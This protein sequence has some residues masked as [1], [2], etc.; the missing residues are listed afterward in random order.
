V[1]AN[2]NGKNP[3]DVWHINTQPYPEAHFAVFPIE[4]VKKPILAG[5]PEG[6]HVLDPFGGSGTVAEF[7]RMNDRSCT[8]YELN[9]EYK[10]LIEDRAM[11][12]TP[13]LFSY[14]GVI[15]NAV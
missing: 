3:G 7:C 11:I 2:A 10:S 6:G 15:C 1:A 5:C 8:I 13:D 4:L 9:P 14:D 12:K